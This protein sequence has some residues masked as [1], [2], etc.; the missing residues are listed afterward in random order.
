MMKK[1]I[2]NSLITVVALG[3]AT[4]ALAEDTAVQTTATVNASASG[5]KPP[6]PAKA[7]VENR[8]ASSTEKR[9]ERM[10][11]RKERIASTTERMQEK[12]EEMKDRLASSSEKR[13]ER[14][15]DRKERMMKE[16]KR[17]YDKM[18]K[19]IE[20]TIQREETLMGKLNDRIAKIKAAGGTTAEAEKMTADAKVHIDAA[21]TDLASL[22]LSAST[23]AQTLSTTTN[24]VKKENLDKM[25]EIEK[26][27]EKHLKEAHKLL[28]KAVGNLKGMSQLKN[29]KATTTPT[30]TTTGTN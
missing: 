17:Q 20:A 28:E 21:K 16:L 5:V 26:G 29:G 8:I 13:Q 14:V 24:A 22:K 4:V 1:L 9:Q 6:R 11:D 19:R 2:I 18:L 30:A 7:M 12:R 10:E 27:I 25:R 15:E 3:S 23:T